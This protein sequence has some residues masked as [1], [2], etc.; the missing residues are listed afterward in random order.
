MGRPQY[1]KQIQEDTES[2]PGGDHHE[3]GSVREAKL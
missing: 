3:L 2:L 1:F